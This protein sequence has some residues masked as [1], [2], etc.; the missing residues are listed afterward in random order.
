MRFVQEVDY[1]AVKSIPSIVN[2]RS[3]RVLGSMSGKEPIGFDFIDVVEI[4]NLD[5][6]LKDLEENPAVEEVHSRSLQLVDIQFTAVSE[7]VGE[8]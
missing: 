5:S 1:A 6:Y 7:I 8:G 3:N 2:Y 4:T